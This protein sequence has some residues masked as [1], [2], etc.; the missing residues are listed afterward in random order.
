M[1]SGNCE[2]RLGLGLGFRGNVKICWRE[3]SGMEL[4]GEF[5]EREEK[6]ERRKGREA[7]EAARDSCSWSC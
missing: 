3:E 2:G 6:A 4:D 7:V 1:R 5:W